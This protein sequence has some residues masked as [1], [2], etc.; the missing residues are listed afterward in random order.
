MKHK[1]VKC[2]RMLGLLARL[3]SCDA[4]R[5]QFDRCGRSFDCRGPEEQQQRDGGCFGELRRVVL[6]IVVLT[7][8]EQDGNKKISDAVKDDIAY[9]AKRNADASVTPAQRLAE[10]DAMK[11]V[12]FFPIMFVTRYCSCCCC[13]C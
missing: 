10:V 6:V 2:D 5:E 13:C 8:G 7:D 9:F 12:N 4:G 1:C 11:E 3:M